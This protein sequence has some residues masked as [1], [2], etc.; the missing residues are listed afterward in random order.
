MYQLSCGN[1]GLID[2]ERLDTGYAGHQIQS[3]PQEHHQR[4]SIEFA[5]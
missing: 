3:T 1:E 5:W 2:V 4:K